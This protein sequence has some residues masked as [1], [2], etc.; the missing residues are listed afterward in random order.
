[1]MGSWFIPCVGASAVEPGAKIPTRERAART[2]SIWVREDKAPDRTATAVFG[3]VWFS[4][5]TISADNTR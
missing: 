3:D 1:F 5:R 2:R 4:S